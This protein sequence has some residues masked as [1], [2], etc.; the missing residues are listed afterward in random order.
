[1]KHLLVAT[2]LILT[3]P[4][5]A[6][7]AEPSPLPPDA[8]RDLVCQLVV[9]DAANRIEHLPEDRQ[10]KVARMFKLLV[11]DPVAHPRGDRTEVIE[12]LTSLHHSESFFIGVI[13]GRL[14]D[15]QITA[16]SQSANAELEKAKASPDEFAEVLQFC[17]NDAT[18]RSTHYVQ[19][20]TAH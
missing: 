18:G 1:M 17:L 5:S 15:A 12:M 10:A 4:I 2:A 19:Q 3:Q 16:A 14:S 8:G 20:L 6:L 7:A 13:V 9:S 11:P